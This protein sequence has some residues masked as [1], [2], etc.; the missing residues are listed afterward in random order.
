MRTLA[1]EVFQLLLWYLLNCFLPVLVHMHQ[2]RVAMGD[3]D[4]EWCYGLA[5]D[6]K[7][8]H[9]QRTLGGTRPLTKGINRGK[10]PQ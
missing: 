9:L 6:A 7:D 10:P 4:K 1:P 8:L 2:F 3:I 5:T